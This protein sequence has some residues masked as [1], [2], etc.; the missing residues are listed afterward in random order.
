MEE[1]EGE[2]EGEEGAFQRDLIE[3][4]RQKKLVEVPLK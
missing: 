3:L 2:G 4:T 1:G